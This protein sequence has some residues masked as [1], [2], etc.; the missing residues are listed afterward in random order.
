MLRSFLPE[1]ILPVVPLDIKAKATFY[2]TNGGYEVLEVKYVVL[3]LPTP[4]FDG[5]PFGH[6]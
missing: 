3:N 1:V 5:Q 6:V 2:L 4:G